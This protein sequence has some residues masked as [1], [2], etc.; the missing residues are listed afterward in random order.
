MCFVTV[1]ASCKASDF[2]LLIN[3][4]NTL[5]QAPHDDSQTRHYYPELLHD[6]VSPTSPGVLSCANAGDAQIYYFNYSE[7]R[8]KGQV[9]LILCSARHPSLLLSTLAQ[10]LLAG[11]NNVAAVSSVEAVAKDSSGVQESLLSTWTA[12]CQTAT[13]QRG[14]LD[15]LLTRV[16]APNLTTSCRE[17]SQYA[18]LSTFDPEWL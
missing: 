5:V 2:P 8:G 15:D 11:L 12:P 17:D 6:T 16:H 4:L 7:F 9:T 1:A 10:S 13:Q 14:P 18:A 3:N